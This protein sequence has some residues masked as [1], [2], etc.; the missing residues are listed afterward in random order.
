MK[1][2]LLIVL[3]LFI[4]KTGLAQKDKDTVVYNLP[5]V[6]GKLV[7][8]GTVN[9]TGHNSAKL[10]SSA[11]KWVTSHFKYHEPDTLSKDKDTTAISVLSWAAI[12]YHIKPG[13][14]SIPFYLIITI[15]VNCQNNSY[16]YK[17]FNIYFR[18]QSR[19]LST[20]GYQ[21]DPSYLIML[22]KQKHIGFIHSMSIDRS[23]IRE[24]LS[25]TNS[26][27]RDCIASLNKAMAN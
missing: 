12:E 1:R 9:V 25:G 16:S 3:F 17:I 19:A 4:A 10:D 8:T 11:K 14:I 13:L 6:D 2:L 15:K 22:Y 7:Y 26:A 20:I 21:R 23:M 24:Y 27:I 18:P 5:V